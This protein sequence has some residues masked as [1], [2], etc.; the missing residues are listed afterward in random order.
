MGQMSPPNSTNGAGDAALAA[1][2]PGISADYSG[3]PEPISTTTKPPR[4]RLRSNASA[5]SLS[6]SPKGRSVHIATLSNLGNLCFTNAIIQVL[7]YTRPIREYFLDISFPNTTATKLLSGSVGEADRSPSPVGRPR[8]RQSKRLKTYLSL[9]EVDLSSSFASLTRILWAKNSIDSATTPQKS[10]T[11]SSNH[12]HVSVVSPLEFFN[13]CIAGLPEL[14]ADFAQQD[15]Q[16]FLRCILDKIHVELLAKQRDSDTAD[17]TII[18][19]AF[20]GQL[21]STV[22]CLSCMY[23]S[24]TFDPFLDLSLDIPTESVYATEMLTL[25]KL[26]QIFCGTETLGGIPTPPQSSI[27]TSSS[28]SMVETEV[29]HQCTMC[30]AIGTSSKALQIGKCPDVLCIHLKRFHWTMAPRKVINPGGSSRIKRRPAVRALK[31]GKN[32]SE[33]L[34][35]LH[36]LDMTPYMLE[37]NTKKSLYNL[38]GVVVHLGKG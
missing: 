3:L 1:T 4:K 29:F 32:D 15:A 19:D 2:S 7:L 11:R 31:Q 5:D 27:D 34:F 6:S 30:H 22:R 16:E 8:T 13:H 25:E 26:L 23:T 33:I 9:S 18:T 28:S 36:S 17:C 35:P 10:P 21:C 12:I 38:Y 14:F 37:G 20:G 24:Y